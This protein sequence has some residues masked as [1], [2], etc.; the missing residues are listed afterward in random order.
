M[1]LC[2]SVTSWSSSS[3]THLPNF[4]TS[5]LHFL[6]FKSGLTPE[7]LARNEGHIDSYLYLQNI[8]VTSPAQQMYSEFDREI[9][10]WIGDLVGPGSTDII[11]KSYK[12]NHKLFCCFDTEWLRDYSLNLVWNIIREHIISLCTYNTLL[13]DSESFVLYQ[14]IIFLFYFVE[15]SGLCLDRRYQHHTCCLSVRLLQNSKVIENIIAIYFAFCSLTNNFSYLSSNK[16][17][18]TFFFSHYS[19]DNFFVS[20]SLCT[21]AHIS[22]SLV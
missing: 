6:S 13:I 21:V 22:N 1:C 10:I 2:L 20:F 5:P 7:S 12:T 11:C 16:K 19:A 4:S 9:S 8:R 3:Y 14:I 17:I 18:Q 15:C